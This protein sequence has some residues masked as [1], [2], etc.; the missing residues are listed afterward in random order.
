MKNSLKITL[1][2]VLSALSVALLALGSIIWILEYTAPLLCGMILIIVVE[3]CGK[4]TAFL[5]YAAV[6]V[7]SLILLPMKGSAL[8][9]ATF[10]GYFPI[11]R[12]NI[13]RLK[14]LIL[15]I[16]IKFVI[17]NVGVIG[18]E[19][20]LV[21]AF[22]IPFDNPFGATGLIITLAASYVILFTFDRLLYVFTVI[23]VKKYKKRVEKML[24]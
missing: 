18:T 14:L 4:K 19:L 23:Y 11:I 8:L 9:Y 22:G 7:L 21:Y 17:F 6:S 1:A 13:D 12:E 16:L 10:F 3:S 20:L 24:K 5:V 2:G 15:R